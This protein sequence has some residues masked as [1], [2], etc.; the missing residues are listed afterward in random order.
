[1]THTMS[2][3]PLALAAL[4]T[5]L[6]GALAAGQEPPATP[7]PIFPTSEPQGGQVVEERLY[8]FT[9][10]DYDPPVRVAPVARAAAAYDNPEQAAIAQI[11][12]MFAGDLDWHRST[13]TDESRVMMDE[14]DQR[15]GRGAEFWQQRWAAALDGKTP[16]L[17]QRVDTGEFVFIVAKVVPE[18]SAPGAD[19]EQEEIEL[20]QVLRSVDG[21]WLGTQELASDP[22]LQYWRNPGYRTQRLMRG[23]TEAAGGTTEQGGSP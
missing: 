9:T 12:A 21:R 14:R 7:T 8:Y 17:T 4:C 23:F 5:L 20:L 11:S 18:G 13:W 3:Q 15:L 2:K 19:P 16:Y 6:G 22:V 10:R 1:M